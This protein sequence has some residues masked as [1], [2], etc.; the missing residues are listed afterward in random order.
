[1]CTQDVRAR[2]EP[3]DVEL[4]DAAVA[5]LSALCEQATSV[6]VPLLL[7]AEASPRQPA[8]DVIA[9]ELMRRFNR[10]SGGSAEETGAGSANG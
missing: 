10:G 4:F 6:G 9:L 7:D 3:S 1:M 8:V 2:L 5:N